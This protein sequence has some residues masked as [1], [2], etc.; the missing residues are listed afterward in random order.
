MRDQ[1]FRILWVL[2]L[3]M[4][5]QTTVDLRT[6]SKNVDFS[7]APST[8][9]IQTGATVPSTCAI[10]Q[11]FFLTTAP[12]GANL[13]G[14]ESTNIWTLESG[15]SGGGSGATAADQ[16]TDAVC[17][18]TSNTVV[19]CSF[20]VGGTNFGNS[21]YSSALTA[22][23]TV[24]IASTSG[25]TTF[26]Q[27]W[28]PASPGTVSIDTTASSFS[29]V[30][31]NSGCT[32]ANSNSSGYPADVKPLSRLTAGLTANQ[33]DSFVNCVPANAQG[34][35]DDRAVLSI[36]VVDAGTNLT[37]ALASHGVK[38]INIDSTSALTW[39]GSADFSGASVTRPAQ[40]GATN[41][42][43]CTAG[44]D[45]FIN[46]SSTPQLELCTAA[47]S[48]TGVGGGSS[49]T[50]TVYNAPLVACQGGSPVTQSGWGDSGTM[51]S[52]CNSIGALGSTAQAGLLH[53][54]AS[55]DLLFNSFVVPSNLTRLDVIVN[56]FPGA[57]TANSLTWTAQVGCIAGNGVTFNGG[58]QNSGTAASISSTTTNATAQFVM[59]GVSTS[60]CNAND[61]MYLVLGRSGT[62][63]SSYYITSIE[64]RATRTLP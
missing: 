44:K 49:G 16:L 22:S 35:I 56:G 7:A 41:P 53:S 26:Y 24:T 59:T 20:P 39:T 19:T 17:A 50:F 46:T 13:Y 33:W 63:A 64:V 18:R 58:S 12:A 11:M 2:S 30:T 6:Q 31:C 4:L 38:T 37:S 61:Q 8:K 60:G 32:L 23:W 51:S 5:A 43:T 40:S 9:P 47:N 55:G 36:S 1:L 62:Y 15:G 57:T 52:Q 54:G 45:M 14:C 28:N 27:Y 42:S 34:C 21:N 25:A 29:G 10:G 3:P 48:W